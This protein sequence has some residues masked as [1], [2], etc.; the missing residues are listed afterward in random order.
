[1]KKGEKLASKMPIV[2][3]DSILIYLSEIAKYKPLA[4]AEEAELGRRIKRDDKAALA[5]LIKS[6]LRFVVS[7]ARTYEHQ[8]LPLADLI[9]EGNLGLIK[10]AYKFDDTKNFRFISYAVWW[11]RQSILKALADHS[12]AVKLPV[13]KVGQIQNVDRERTRLQQK[14]GRPPSRKEIAESL[15]AKEDSVAESLRLLDKT[16]SLN[17]PVATNQSRQYIDLI[18]DNESESPDEVIERE[19]KFDRIAGILHVLPLR[20][21]EILCMYYG[22]GYDVTFT[23]DEIGRKL[24]LTRERVRQLRDRA[25]ERLRDENVIAA[26]KKT[27][28]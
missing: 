2:D 17:S 8:G 21:R 20:E 25:L 28:T 24:S 10:A 6:N 27:E 22:F 15:G 9:N 7:V 1:M 18:T 26:L 11:I 12:R 14:L 3:D 19:S 16:L 13:N 23:L 4:T 5:K